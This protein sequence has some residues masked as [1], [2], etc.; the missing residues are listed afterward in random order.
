M[1]LLLHSIAYAFEPTGEYTYTDPDFTG[2]MK[3][4]ENNS[5]SRKMTMVLH[6]TH[7]ETGHTCDVEVV[8]VRVADNKNE[9]KEKFTDNIITFFVTFTPY[10]ATIEEEFEKFR[11]V[12]GLH[13]SFSGKWIKNGVKQPDK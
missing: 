10:G 3:I 7:T 8:G 9:I 4:K 13:A 1:I 2:T 12:C 11:W 6:T 5:Y